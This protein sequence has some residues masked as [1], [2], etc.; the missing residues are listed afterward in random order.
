VLLLTARDAVDDRVVGLDA[1]ADDY[2][3]KSF[4][5]SEL[6]ACLRALRPACRHPDGAV[7]L[8]ASA[9]M[10]FADELVC[11]ARGACTGDGRQL[12][13]LGGTRR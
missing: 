10:V 1:G 8:V 9:L 11:H 3:V 13:R 2:L 12:L 4:S 6:L 7:R 5:F